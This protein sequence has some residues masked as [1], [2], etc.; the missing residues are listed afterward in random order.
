MWY[1]GIVYTVQIAAFLAVISTLYGEF[2]Q[3]LSD[4]LSKCTLPFKE[5]MC[6]L[7]LKHVSV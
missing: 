2:M 4:S 5:V 6:L 1:G 7:R 3:V